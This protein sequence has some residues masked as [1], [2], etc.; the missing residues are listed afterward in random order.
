M[1]IDACTCVFV[2]MWRK[3]NQEN[4]NSSSCVSIFI[5][6][7]PLCS[8]FLAHFV[9]LMPRRQEDTQRCMSRSQQ[10]GEQRCCREHSASVLQQHVS[11]L[12]QG[13]VRLQAGLLQPL[14]K[15]HVSGL[16]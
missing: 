11:P 14:V 1:S 4:A 12:A 8:F 9:F 15:C 5:F 7:F 13:E 10:R 16:P 6:S 3:R 2:Y